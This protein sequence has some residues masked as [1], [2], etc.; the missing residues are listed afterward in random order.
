MVFVLFCFLMGG[1]VVGFLGGVGFCGFLFCFVVVIVV[2]NFS[3][4]EQSVITVFANYLLCFS[5]TTSNFRRNINF[6]YL[7]FLF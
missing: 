3:L 6:L 7:I 2:L 1:W 5:K 4:Q